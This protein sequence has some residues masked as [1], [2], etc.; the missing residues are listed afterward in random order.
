M[1][2][3]PAAGA[4][5]QP[6]SEAAAQ[7]PVVRSYGLEIEIHFHYHVRVMTTVVSPISF[8]TSVPLAL[9]RQRLMTACECAGVPFSEIARLVLVEGRPFQDVLERTGCGQ[10][11]TACIPDLHRYLAASG[12]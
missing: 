11:C 10:T 5:E 7:A 6:L 3:C 8:D 2:D 9:R 12:D 1:S 4:G